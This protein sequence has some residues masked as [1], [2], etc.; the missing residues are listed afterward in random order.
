MSPENAYTKASQSPSLQ[1]VAL[2]DGE[3]ENHA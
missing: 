2:S 3:M 1:L